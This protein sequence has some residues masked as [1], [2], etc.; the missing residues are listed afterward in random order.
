MRN[1]LVKSRKWGLYLTY[2]LYTLQLNG[3]FC[4]FV[5]LCCMFFFVVLLPLLIR[6][7]IFF[8]MCSHAALFSLSIF[9]YL[10]TILHVANF[11]PMF[12]QCCCCCC[13]FFCRYFFLSSPLHIRIF[14]LHFIHN[15]VLFRIVS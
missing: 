4:S 6:F 1:E 10:F 15:T 13:Y 7:L 5:E 3:F 2:K 12:W 8:S 11:K 9:H 14:F